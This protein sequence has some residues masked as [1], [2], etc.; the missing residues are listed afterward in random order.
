MLQ[1]VCITILACLSNVLLEA[2]LVDEHIDVAR[3]IAAQ[4]F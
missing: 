2:L 1:C 4:T 3:V